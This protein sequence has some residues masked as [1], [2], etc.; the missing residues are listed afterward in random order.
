MKYRIVHAGEAAYPWAHKLFTIVKLKSHH[1]TKSQD[2][3]HMKV[4]FIFMEVM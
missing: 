3:P 1:L 2:I 4:P